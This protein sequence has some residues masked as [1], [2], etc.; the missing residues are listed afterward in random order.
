[1]VEIAGNQRDYKLQITIWSIGPK[2]IA[3][4]WWRVVKT[5]HSYDNLTVYNITLFYKL[6]LHHK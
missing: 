1:M 3:M 4:M 6:Q 2:T 5:Y